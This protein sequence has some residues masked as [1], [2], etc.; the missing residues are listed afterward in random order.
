MI[1]V[2]VVDDSAIVRKIFQRELGKDPSITVVGTAPDPYVARDKIIS[3]KPD[4]VTLD[5]EMPRMD[6]VTFLRKIM[7]YN[8]LPV[9]IISSLSDKSSNIAMEAMECGAVDVLRKPGTSYT[10]GDMAIELVDKVK[11][12]SK[13]NIKHKALVSKLVKGN[14]EVLSIN[15]TTH[16]ILAIGASTGGTVALDS[17]LSKMPYNSPGTIITQHMP[18]YF[19]K[20][21]AMRLNAQSK[22]T[23]KE[24]CDGDTVSMGTALIAPGDKHMLLRRSGARYYVNIKDGPFVNRHRPSVDVMFKSV[25]QVAGKNAVGVI[26][27]GMGGDGAKGMFEMKKRGAINIAQDEKSCVVFGMPKVAIETGAVDKIVSLEKI[28]RAIIKSIESIT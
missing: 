20:S 12:A 26:L 25:S 18:K 23:V 9:I 3:L 7:K 10:V 19:T 16:Q 2:L 14:R 22:M 8:P 24:A 13:V 27:T 11:A 6:G 21:F 5:L 17:L 15:I 4:V 28:P 1:K